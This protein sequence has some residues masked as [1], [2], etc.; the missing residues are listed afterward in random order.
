MKNLLYDPQYKTV[1]REMEDKLYGM[2]GELGGME[3]PLNRPQG[4]APTNASAAVAA[5]TPRL[6]DPLV[7]DKPLNLDAN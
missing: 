7:V 1:T 2:M 5:S 4:A 3:I 6:P